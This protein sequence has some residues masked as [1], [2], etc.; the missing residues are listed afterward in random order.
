MSCGCGDTAAQSRDLAQ[1]GD[2]AQAGVVY[3]ELHR[4]CLLRILC[5]AS[6]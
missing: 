2:D 4:N 3:E 1:Q 5:A 6:V